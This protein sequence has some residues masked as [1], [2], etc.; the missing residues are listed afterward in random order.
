VVV[1]G[2]GACCV[3][4]E[5]GGR[6]VQIDGGVTTVVDGLNKPQGL[7]LLGDQLLILDVGS[8]E[9]IGFSFATKQ[10]H[11]LA[12]N[13]PV[14]AAPGITPKPLAGI[15]GL[16]PGPLSPFADVAVGS[17]GTIYIAAD[18]EGSV[19]ALKRS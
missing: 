5:R 4:D 2:N 11:T 16:I 14:G 15:D 1:A 17:D 3:S 10:R 19:L 9:L 13:L 8:R 12:S 7:A 6:V 18:G